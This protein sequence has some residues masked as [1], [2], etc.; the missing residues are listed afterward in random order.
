MIQLLVLLLVGLLI[1]FAVGEDIKRIL[2]RRVEGYR[3]KYSKYVTRSVVTPALIF[4]ALA[5]L[6]RDAILTPFV[7]AIA[8]GVIY[9][10]VSQVIAATAGVSPRDILQMVIAFRAAYQLQPAAFKS[11]EMAATKVHDPL[12]GIINTVVNIY[13]NSSDSDLA[14]DAF[15]RRVGDNVLLKQFIYILEMSSSASD[16]SMTEALDAFVER[17]RRQQELQREV[18][19]NL[20]GITGQTSFMQSLAIGIAFIIAL[21]PESRAVYTTLLGRVAYMFLMAIIM[22]ASYI[23]E[24]KVI[25]LKEE[26][27]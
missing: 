14:F 9:F 15:R 1:Y 8:G 3:V 24:K 26:I 6:M 10:R 7:L 23:I 17:L 19:T 4:V 20:S 25:S 22:G 5:V 12:K 2:G 27:L 11:L 21:V 13:F 18:E 16:E